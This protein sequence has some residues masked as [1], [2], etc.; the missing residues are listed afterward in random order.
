MWKD[1]L[2]GSPGSQAGIPRPHPMLLHNQP[3]AEQTQDSSPGHNGTGDQGR[4]LQT[5]HCAFPGMEFHRP[6][7]HH[8]RSTSFPHTPV[9][10]SSTQHMAP[11]QRRATQNRESHSKTDSA[12]LHR[13]RLTAQVLDTVISP[14]AAA[15]A[16]FQENSV[17]SHGSAKL[18]IPSA[19]VRGQ[20]LRSVNEA[21]T[22]SGREWISREQ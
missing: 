15:G 6:P 2:P 20:D 5:F 11:L 22:E 14:A 16:R 13:R 8:T 9:L 7:L 1:Q 3:Q 4:V 17:W 21:A 10:T 12:I 19:A 18:V